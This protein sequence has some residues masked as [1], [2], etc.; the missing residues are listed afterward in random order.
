MALWTLNS[1]QRRSAPNRDTRR[2]LSEAQSFKEDWRWAGSLRASLAWTP[3]TIV[4]SV[5]ALRPNILDDVPELSIGLV[6]IGIILWSVDFTLAHHQATY[7]LRFQEARQAAKG[8][9]GAPP[10]RPDTPYFFSFAFL[11][12]ILLLLCGLHLMQR[13]DPPVRGDYTPFQFGDDLH[14]FDD[15]AQNQHLELI[16]ADWCRVRLAGDR[17]TFLF[18]GSADVRDKRT[19]PTNDQLARLRAEF[20]KRRVEDLV[21]DRIGRLPGSIGVA[22]VKGRGQSSAR[23]EQPP[24][25]YAADRSVEVVLLVAA[26]ERLP[27][28]DRPRFEACAESGP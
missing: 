2:Q 25:G 20:V 6:V 14:A 19:A 8:T 4:V 21:R 5:V 11:V 13:S 24:G 18:V 7:F 22:V 1:L 12:Y 26:A 27:E 16:A 15:A 9:D 17:G 3:L 10:Q 28:E 23:F